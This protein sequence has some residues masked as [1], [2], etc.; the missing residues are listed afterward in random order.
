MMRP[1]IAVAVASVSL[2]S[3]APQARAQTLADALTFLVTN[4]SVP[5]GSIERDRDAAQATSETISRALL[6]NLAT[7]PVASSS[8]AFVYRLNPELGTVERKTQA[9]GPFFLERALTAGRGRA[10]LGLTVQ[11]LHFTSLDGRSLTDGSLVTTANQFTDESTPFDVDRLTLDVNADVATLYGS[12]GITNNMEI[13]FAAPMVSLSIDGS[14]VNTYR[15][16]TFTQASASGRATG[17]ADLVVR[18]KYTLYNEGAA[19][20]AGAVDVRLPTGREDDLL[21]TGS[22]SYKF[23]TIGSLEGS[24]TSAHANAGLQVGGLATE[25]SYG[26]A[27]SVAATTTVSVVGEL[28]GRWINSSGRVVSTIAPHPLLNGVNTIRLA[29]DSSSLQIVTLVPGVKWNVSDTWVLA[30]NVSMPLTSGG[31]NARFTPFVGLDYA[32]GR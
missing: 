25:I 28:L 10:S 3:S 5:T 7:L 16:R 31:L 26:A 8:G 2:V 30:A 20:L 11:H 9:F 6:A 24:R 18:T 15:G 4:Q 21:G 13:G 19:A 1:V 23:S 14:R 17:L 32:V 12:V 27:V 29:G 22:T